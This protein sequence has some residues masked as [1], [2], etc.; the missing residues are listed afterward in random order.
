MKNQQNFED[1]WTASS[2]NRHNIR[3]FAQMFDNYD[4]DDK[5]MSL[6]YPFD[7]ELLRLEKT[8][9][10][11]IS[12][13]RKSVREFSG[14][15]LSMKELSQILSSFYAWNGLEHRGFPSA[16]ATYATEI[17]VAAFNVEKYN[18]S[19]LYYDAQKHAV[20]KVAEAPSW[21]DAKKSLNVSIKGEPAVLVVFTVF[22]DRA[23]MKYGERGG[24][25]VLLEAGAAMQQL[26]LQVAASKKLKG[27]ILGGAYDQT[28]KDV[29]GLR[30]T[31]AKIACCYLLGK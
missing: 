10:N 29:L 16:G 20:V 5:Q 11:T 26:S 7:S 18:G 19:I 13:R 2:L 4:S 8:A 22:D 3:E 27:V 21:R 23:M 9:L 15:S 31:E 12:K 6:E 14:E 28:W 30:H 24:R 25:F 17:F 1:F